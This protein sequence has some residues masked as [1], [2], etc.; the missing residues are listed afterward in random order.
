MPRFDAAQ[1]EERAWYACCT[2]PPY[3]AHLPPS[4]IS[5]LLLAGCAVAHH[6]RAWLFRPRSLQAAIPTYHRAALANILPLGRSKGGGSM[7]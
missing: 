4:F 2:S 6:M 5:N 1:K 7:Y 3:R